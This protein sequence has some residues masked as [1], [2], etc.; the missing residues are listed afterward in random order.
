VLNIYVVYL[1]SILAER[2]D[3]SLIYTSWE[4]SRLWRM[5][6]Y[7]TVLVPLS[8]LILSVDFGKKFALSLQCRA[9]RSCLTYSP[10]NSSSSFAERIKVIFSQWKHLA[11]L[12]PACT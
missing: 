7:R 3:A 4:Y 10:Q 1:S 2:T 11:I 6:C 8:L 9:T 12:F 5:V